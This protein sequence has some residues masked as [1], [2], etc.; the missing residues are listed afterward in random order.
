[1]PI[2]IHGISNGFRFHGHAVVGTLLTVISIVCH[3]NTGNK[4]PDPNTATIKNKITTIKKSP[5]HL[6]FAC[7]DLTTKYL[8][9]LDKY[10]SS[11]GGNDIISMSFGALLLNVH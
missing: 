10:S 5:I 2:T 1:V 8:F 7:F 3:I 6:G 4:V 9:L 11:I